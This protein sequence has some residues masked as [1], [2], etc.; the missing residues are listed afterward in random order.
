MPKNY[1]LTEEQFVMLNSYALHYMNRTIQDLKDSKSVEI[2]GY[3]QRE[4]DQCSDVLESINRK[5][6]TYEVTSNYHH[7]KLNNQ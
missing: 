2:S 3:Y 1:T 6:D 5:Y 7:N 4:I